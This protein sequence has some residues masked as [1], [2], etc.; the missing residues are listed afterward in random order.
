MSARRRKKKS[1]V[2]KAKPYLL[3]GLRILAA[4]ALIGPPLGV[5]VFSILPVPLTPLM[6]FRL[7]DGQGLVR[8]SVPLSKISPELILAVI[9]SEDQRFCLHD[10]FDWKAIDLA[11][12]QNASGKPLRG[13]STITQQT[14]KN[15]LL[16]PG[17]DWF[18]KGL[19]AYST[20]FIEALW[21]KSHVLE[22]YLNVVEWGPGIYGAEAAARYHFG[23]TAGTLDAGEAARLAVILPAPRDWK[24]NPPGPYIR[25][26]ARLIE[27]RMRQVRSQGLA[28]CV[29]GLRQGLG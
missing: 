26:R 1:V 13:A 28:R 23:K 5:L 10:G 22:T 16:W 15:V 4:V 19:E 21:S 6:A 8:V 12:A 9:A 27:A 14:A 18:R 29:L 25:E 2:Q 17:R 20:L 11:A 7:A 3:K 24:A